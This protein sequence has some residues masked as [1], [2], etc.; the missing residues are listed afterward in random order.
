MGIRFLQ[1]EPSSSAA[2]LCYGQHARLALQFTL[3]LA[4]T[5]DN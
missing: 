5:D 3:V 1:R 2:R 4:I